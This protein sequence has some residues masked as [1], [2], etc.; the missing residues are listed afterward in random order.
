MST[1][2]PTLGLTLYDSSTDQVVTFATFRAVWG[3]TATTSNF[4]KIDTWAG[5]VN[6]SISTLQNQRGAIT[7]SASYISANYYEASV[8]SITSYTTGMNILLKL[9]TDSAGTVTLNISSLGTK[10]VTKVNSSGTVVNISAGELQAGR[11]YLFTYDGTQWVWVD[12]N[13]SDQIYVVS[14]VS[15]NFVRVAST[16]MMEDSGQNS[17]SFI[18][19][20]VIS[21]ASVTTSNVTGV[22][23][24]LHILDVSGMTA[25]RDFNLPTPSMAGVRCAVRLSVGDATYALILKINSVEWSRIFITGETVFF[26]STGTGAGD[27]IVEQDGRIPC[28]ARIKNTNT[29]NIS[30]NTLTTMVLDETEF[31]NASLGNTSTYRIT[32]RRTGKYIF[33]AFLK[34]DNV[35]VMTRFATG[36]YKNGTIYVTQDEK[37]ASAASYPASSPATLD[38]FT[39]GDYVELT[40]LQNGGSTEPTYVTGF[41]THLEVIEI[42]SI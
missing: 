32:S 31:D 37:P 17:T 3:G 10:S 42:L 26:V 6:S 36:I 34:L 19:P 2:T 41:S 27:W 20:F 12:A 7:V 23:G 15:G 13:S 21:S 9:D 18:K 38:I 5:T 25:N 35:A 22:E 8:A 4:Y 33:S 29:Q 28:T 24:T 1:T 14:G 39:E 11:Y 16:G 30:H 40:C